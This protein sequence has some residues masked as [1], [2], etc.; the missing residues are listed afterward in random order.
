MLVKSRLEKE[1]R[2]IISVAPETSVLDMM[3]TMITKKVGCLPVVDTKG[4]LKGIVDDK[5][6]FRAVHKESTDFE[7]LTAKDLMATDLLIGLPTDDINY[8]AGLMSNNNIRYV[9]IMEKS[10]MV[11]LMSQGDVMEAQRRHIEIENRYL[12]LYMDGTHHG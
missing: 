8:I 3:E 7:K 10:K 4:E 11:G 1:K 9:P 5:D 12:K 6:I 2:E